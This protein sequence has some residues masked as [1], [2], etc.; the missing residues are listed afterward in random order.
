MDYVV[1][2]LEIVDSRIA[3]W[4]I[5]ITDT[6][7]DNASSGLFVLAIRRALTEFEP[8]D[9]AMQLHSDGDLVSEGTGA[10]CLGDPLAA[11][12]WLARTAASFGQPLR[13]GQ[14][15]LSG[16]LGPLVPITPGN[17]FHAD[18]GPLGQVAMTF[19]AEET[20]EQDHGRDHRV[21][22]H[23]HHPD[24]ESAPVQRPR[25]GNVGWH[26]PR[27]RRTGPCPSTTSAVVTCGGQAT[28]P[29][30]AA[31]GRMDWAGSCKDQAGFIVNAL[32]I[33]YLCSAIRM[34]ETGFARAEDIDDGMIHGCAHPM[35][36]L[37]LTDTIGLDVTLAV[38]ESLY[39]EFREPHHAPPVLLRRKVEAG[40]PRPQNRP[41]LL[42]LLNCRISADK[43]PGPRSFTCTT[44]SSAR[45]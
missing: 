38:A 4:D 34:L 3:G 1:A 44:S 16:A 41:R 29:K 30:V 8:R 45:P 23:R 27:L 33:P 9:A 28:I 2:A 15:V 11:L 25:D 19:S 17:R 20:N 39:Q 24:D 22:Q 37:R 31:V 5:S 36:P 43:P 10:A 40:Q 14:M 35:R 6:I 26:R 21:R 42:H 18:I 12:A 7:A 13:A 32:L